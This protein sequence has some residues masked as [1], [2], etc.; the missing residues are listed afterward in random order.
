MVTVALLVLGFMGFARLGSDLFPDVSFPAVVVT[1]PYPGAG[2][3][4]VETLVSKPLEDSVVSINGIDRV[5]SFSREGSSMLF[6]MFNLGVDVKDAA[7][8]VR[9]RISQVRYRLPTETKEPVVQRFDVSA[10]PVL[11]YTLRGSGSL[12]ELRAYADEVLRPA[13]EQVEGVA[14]VDVKGGAKREIRVELDR[15][16]VDALQLSPGQIVQRLRME[17]LNV[18]AGHYDEGTREISVRTMAEFTDVSQIRETIVATSAN[19]SAVKLRD[20]A[21][22]SDG[23]E[24]QRLRVRVNG[25][26]AVTFEVRKRSGQNTVEVAQL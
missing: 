4:E 9:E 24:D 22:V 16:R 3:A 19:G 12:S 7:T 20:I 11:T 2:P 25:E 10:A 23:F 5:R 21:N 18:P 13:L 14:A 1:V 6:V 8:E 17:N 15:G 26:E